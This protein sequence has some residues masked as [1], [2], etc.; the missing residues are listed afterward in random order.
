MMTP[1]Q[2]RCLKLHE[3][4]SITVNERTAVLKHIEQHTWMLFG[5]GFDQGHA[6]F[7]NAEQIAEDVNSFE[8]TG[9]IPRTTQ[10]RNW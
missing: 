4:T 10:G 3:V 7:G 8:E 5:K 1:K 6:R 2:A 9:E